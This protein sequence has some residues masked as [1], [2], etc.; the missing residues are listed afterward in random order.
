MQWTQLCSVDQ[1]HFPRL[2]LPH[3]QLWASLIR[4]VDGDVIIS[5][6]VNCLLDASKSYFKQSHVDTEQ[7]Q[8]KHQAALLAEAGLATEAGAELP[9][10]IRQRK[11]FWDRA[12]NVS[13]LKLFYMLMHMPSPLSSLL[14]LIAY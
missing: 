9:S 3:L 2:L 4:R 1:P 8:E 14:V 7:Q 5:V 12:H 6:V 13:S 11:M 10:D